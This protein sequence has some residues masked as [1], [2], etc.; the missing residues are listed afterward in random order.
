MGLDLLTDYLVYFTSIEKLENKT[1]DVTTKGCLF[2]FLDS[3]QWLITS[4]WLGVTINVILI[5]LQSI[6]API[7]VLLVD[8]YLLIFY[9]FCSIASPNS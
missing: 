8:Y 3:M 4:R 5:N 7:I 9:E 2:K 6:N 1:S